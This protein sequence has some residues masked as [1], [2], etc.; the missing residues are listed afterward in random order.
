[1]IIICSHP[2]KVRKLVGA[3]AVALALL[4]WPGTDA[5][6]QLAEPR[7]LPAAPA[8]TPSSRTVDVTISKAR[9][10]DLPAAVRDVLVADPSVAQIVIKSPQRVY[11]LGRSVGATNAFFF[12]A[13]GKEIFR[14][15][16]N[17]RQDIEQVKEAIRILMPDIDVNVTTVNGNLFL[18]GR[19]RSAEISENV[20][21]IAL[22]FVGGASNLVNLIEVIE[23]QQVLLRVRISEVRRNAL[24]Q[25]GVNLFRLIT[26][27]GNLT[28]NAITGS[29]VVPGNSFIRGGVGYTNGRTSIDLAMNALEANGLTRILAEPNLVAI[30]GE[31]A[32]F[33]AGGEIPIPITDNNGNVNVSFEPFG[34]QLRFTP[35]VL[36]SGRIR[37]NIDAEV[38]SLDFASG[39]GLPGGTTV[40]ALVTKRAQ[41]VVELPSGG[42][43]MLAG[44]MD[45]ALSTN[46]SGVPILKDVPILGTLFRNN[47]LQRFENELVV[48]VTA[49][50]IKPVRR[51]DQLKEP[52]DHVAPPSDYDLYALGQIQA[53]YAPGERSSMIKNLRGPI[54]YIVR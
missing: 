54:G 6:A 1:M 41:T 35:L 3:T 34:V 8:G 24:K 51:S 45:D 15:E 26:A 18:T 31:S 23:D 33:L 13:S 21:Q 30:S 46:V 29:G 36:N 47:T 22:R 12:D 40:P 4:V 42:S 43:M 37:L 50:L 5:A 17:V 11:L 27:S 2:F 32:S 38:S 48:M 49:I 20:S 14:A 52:I 10:I 7:I 19:V 44:L 16:I 39:V 25:V 9:I 53:L 28:F